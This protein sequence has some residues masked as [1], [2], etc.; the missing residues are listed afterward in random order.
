MRFLVHHHL[1]WIE[2]YRPQS[3]FILSYRDHEI[4]PAAESLRALN[5]HFY[6]ELERWIVSHASHAVPLLPAVIS[7]W[8]GPMHMYARHWL[9]STVKATP[10]NVT[11]FLADAA[12]HSLEPLLSTPPKG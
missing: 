3:Q 1:T 11:P 9:T 8:I 10:A 7:Q 12:W 2:A 6:S 5:T 4:R